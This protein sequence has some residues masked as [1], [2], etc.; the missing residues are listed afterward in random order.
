MEIV[1]KFRTV[2]FYI[3]II[4]GFSFLVYWLIT[5]GKGLEAGRHV[6]ENAATGSSFQDF[7]DSFVSNI[8]HPAGILLLQITIIIVFARVFG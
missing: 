3:L 2:F 5:Q 6:I 1:K 7:F 8:Q 4:G